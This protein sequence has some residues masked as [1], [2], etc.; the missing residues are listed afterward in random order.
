MSY[1]TF[2]L[3][4]FTLTTSRSQYNCTQASLQKK[5]SRI[6]FVHGYFDLRNYFEAQ[7]EV[8]FSPDCDVYISV[9]LTMN[10]WCCTLFENSRIIYTIG[11]AVSMR[12]GQR[13]RVRMS[14]WRS[15]NYFG[16]S[17]IPSCYATSQLSIFRS[18]TSYSS[19]N[20]VV[21]SSHS[22]LSHNKYTM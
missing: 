21:S 16:R 6:S 15:C 13:E 18:H 5:K 1:S 22:T 2:F 7:E 17:L 3:D 19:M 14:P 11:Y 10:V 20:I 9:L 4:I 12:K 8:E